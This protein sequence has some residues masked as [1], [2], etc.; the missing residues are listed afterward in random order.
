MADRLRGRIQQPRAGAGAS[1]DFRALGAR[2]RRL[3]R[4]RRRSRGRAELGLHYGPTPRQTIDLFKPKG[5]GNGAARAVHPRRLL[6]LARAVELQPDGARHERARRHRRGVGLRSRR[7]RCRS[8]TSSRRRS[9]ACLFLWK[10]FGKRIMVSGHSAGGHLAACMIATDWKKLDAERAGRSRAGGLCDLRPVRSR[11]AAAPRRQR[12]LQARPRRARA[13]S[14]RCSGRR[15]TGRVL[16]AVVGG[17]ESSEFLRQSKI[18]ADAWAQGRRNALRGGPGHEPLH[19]LRCDGR[20][21]QRDDEAA[22]VVRADAIAR[23]T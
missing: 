6:A 17:I 16:D 21:G 14:R 1:A 12:R 2:R 11:A 23:R 22:G 19:R 4:A 9:A 13:R 3:S 5:G 8:P 10:R 20:S 15:R 7:R 18:I